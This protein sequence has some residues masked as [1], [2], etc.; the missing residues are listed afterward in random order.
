MKKLLL[1]KLNWSGAA[2]LFIT[3]THIELIFHLKSPPSQK[4][5][6]EKHQKT[7]RFSDVFTGSQKGTGAQY[8]L[9]GIERIK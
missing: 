9:R 7:L 6:K 3:L 5:Q 4:K 8:G 2:N 1:K